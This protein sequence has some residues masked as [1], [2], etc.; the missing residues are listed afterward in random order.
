MRGRPHWPP[1]PFCQSVRRGAVIMATHPY[2]MVS[3]PTIPA[4][5]WP[6]SS[7]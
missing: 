3:V 2:G 6:G 4:S 7:Q 1:P 5:A